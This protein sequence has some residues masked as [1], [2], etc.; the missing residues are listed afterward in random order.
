MVVFGTVIT[1][2]RRLAHEILYWEL[3][4]RRGHHGVL[5]YTRKGPRQMIRYLVM[6]LSRMELGGLLGQGVLENFV[7]ISQDGTMSFCPHIGK[8]IFEITSGYP[9]MNLYCCF[10]CYYR[11][12][13]PPVCLRSHPPGA[14]DT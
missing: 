9:R 5:D 14:V 13:L 1:L 4:L 3:A 11:C 10:I 12:Y 2:S 6:L 8:Y 7:V